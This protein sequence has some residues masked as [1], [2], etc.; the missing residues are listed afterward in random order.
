MRV[1]PPRQRCHKC[2]KPWRDKVVRI[3]GEV[4]HQGHCD[5]CWK[6]IKEEEEVGYGG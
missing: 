3:N 6:A 4:Y 2:G 5:D 1:T